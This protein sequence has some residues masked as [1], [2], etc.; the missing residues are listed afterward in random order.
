MKNFYHSKIFASLQVRIVDII[1][2]NTVNKRPKNRLP[3]LLN[4]LDAS[5]PASL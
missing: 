5:F 2:E 1:E 3:A 4:T